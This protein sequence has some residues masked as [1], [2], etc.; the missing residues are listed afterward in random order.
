[1]GLGWGQGHGHSG[2]RISAGTQVVGSS[3]RAPPE[4]LNSDRK[5]VREVEQGASDGENPD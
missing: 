3:E 2:E 1:M 4:A 5:T